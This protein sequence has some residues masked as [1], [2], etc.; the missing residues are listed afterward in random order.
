MSSNKNTFYFHFFIIEVLVTM[1]ELFT[2]FENKNIHIGKT[3]NA[4]KI[5]YQSGLNM[6]SLNFLHRDVKIKLAHRTSRVS[7]SSGCS[8]LKKTCLVGSIFL[9]K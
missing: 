2:I 7:F 9:T 4:E 6:Y 1:S 5:K 3:I 8:Y